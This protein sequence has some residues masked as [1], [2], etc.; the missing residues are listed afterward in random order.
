MVRSGTVVAFW[1]TIQRMRKYS[2]KK[3]LAK[4]ERT[5]WAEDHVFQLSLWHPWHFCMVP[6]KSL[7]ADHRLKFMTSIIAQRGR[8]GVGDNQK[9]PTSLSKSNGRNGVTIST[10]AKVINI[11]R[12][13]NK[14]IV[15]CS[16]PEIVD[17]GSYKNDCDWIAVKKATPPRFQCVTK[18]LIHALELALMSSDFGCVG[19]I[20][21]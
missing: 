2:E 6:V 4:R 8:N 16:E 19:T 15:K 11:R 13:V 14:T 12:I 3:R 9:S 5:V 17:E 18:I 21:L 1:K 10:Q 20:S 7:H